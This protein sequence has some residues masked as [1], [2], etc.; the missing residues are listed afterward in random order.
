MCGFT[1][2]YTLKSRRSL[3][4][5][6]NVISG[7]CDA[8]AH[9]GPDHG[10]VWQD[11]DIALNLGHRR[12]SILDLSACGHQP[13]HS[14]SERYVIIFNGEIYNHLALRAEY[15]SDHH[16]SGHSDT[17]TL[18][19]LLEVI[20]F[21][22]TLSAING[23]FAFVL[24]DRKARVLHF[25]RDRFGKKPLYV[26]WA[27]DALV[28]GSELKAIRAHPEFQAEIDTQALA[29]YS[30]YNCVP[31]PHCIYKNIWQVMPGCSLSITIDGMQN[32][33]DL[34]AAMVPYWSAAKIVE[35]RS[36]NNDSHSNIVDEFEDLLGACVKDRMLSDVPLGAFLSGGID[37][38]AIVSLMQAQSTRPVHTY[39][40][41]FEEAG[42]DETHYAREVAAHLGTDHHEHFCS[43]T[44]ALNVI[45]KLPDMYDEPFADQSAIPT[46]LVAQFARRDVSVALSGDGGDEMLGGYSRHFSTPRILK[47]PKAARHVVHAVPQSLL[48]TL[49]PNKP[50]LG[51]HLGK[52]GD[53]LSANTCEDIYHVLLRNWDAAPVLSHSDARLDLSVYHDLE[54]SE[55]LMLWD[56][57]HYLPND[58]L[59]KVDR[60]SMAVSLEARA[61][62]LDQRVF[63]FVWNLPIDLK[64]RDGQGKWLLREVL[65]R[66]VPRHLFERPK[67][68][69]N[70][71]IGQWLRGDLRDW[72][73]DLLDARNL[74]AQGLLDDNVVR[75]TWDA[76]LAGNGHYDEALWN[77]LMFQAWHKRWL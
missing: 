43:A 75:A 35:E 61:P 55:Q 25:A 15:L 67:K 69:F 16:F 40:I 30:N 49:F 12:L 23:M 3:G 27:N 68:G 17:E 58:I 48:N 57:Q 11:P 39:T 13:M 6:H 76:H 1:G 62:L 32:G 41:G 5:D 20:G 10:D 7:M 28:F 72:A 66:H 77:V 70:I 19:A 71:P 60:A 65:A 34:S 14:L 33:T 2:F 4:D 9:R 54:L 59:T 44:D 21:E 73:E 18:L 31:A 74:K 50:L 22:K 47:L 26:G 8:I 46:Y 51:K 45:E 29:L 36:K 42:F 37:S 38:S 53:L 52:M 63:E 64:I 56:T 24:W